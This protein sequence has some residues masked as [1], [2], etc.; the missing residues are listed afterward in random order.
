MPAATVCQ[1][2]P[3]VNKADLSAGSVPFTLWW[4]P[5]VF[6]Q[7]WGFWFEP[8]TRLSLLIPCRIISFLSNTTLPSSV[9]ASDSQD[10]LNSL[11]PHNRRNVP[12]SRQLCSTYFLWYVLLFSVSAG[13]SYHELGVCTHPCFHQILQALLL[14]FALLLLAFAAW[15]LNSFP[16]NGQHG[17]S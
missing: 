6:D 5:S 7:A 17:M 14:M 3:I 4:S 12:L 13:I 10:I 1:G 11:A 15:N 9:L 16:V 2:K 8:A